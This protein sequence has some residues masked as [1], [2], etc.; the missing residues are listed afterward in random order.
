MKKRIVGIVGLVMVLAIA[1]AIALPV[2]AQ[3]G[4]GTDYSGQVDAVPFPEGLEWINVPA[5]LDWAQL[6]GKVVL[7]DFW[8]YGCINCIHIIP[9]L[10]RLEAEYPDELVVIGVHSAKFENEGDTENIRQIVQRYE[11]EHPVVNDS[12][13]TVW[14]AWGVRAWPTAMLVDPQG[15]VFGYHAGEGVYDVL[16][17]IIDG[18]VRQF[19]DAGLI[20]RAPIELALETEARVETLLAFPGKVLADEAGERLF[21]ADSNHNRIVVADL[22]TYEVLEVIGGRD[23]GDMDGSYAVARFS[24]PQGMALSAD[25]SML[26]VADTENHTLRAVDLANQTVQTIAGTGY[27]ARYGARGGIGTEAALSS[28][29]DLVRVDD[30]LYIAMAG[31]HQLW[32]YD[33][34]TGEVGVHSGS[35]R[36]DLIDATHANAELAQPSGITT[37]GSVLYFADSEASAIRASDVDPA[38]GV[39]TLVGTGLF[40]FGDRD[41]V[42]DDALLQHPLGVVYADEV[43][44]VADTYNSK[45][46]VLDPVTREI[47]SLTG[48]Q[49]GG[50][51]DGALDAALFDEPGGISYANGRLYVADTNNHA[52]RVIDLAAGTVESITFTNPDLLLAERESVIVASPFTGNDVM[53]DGVTVAEG[54]AGAALVLTL[55]EGYKV[56][57]LTVSSV[58]W[59]VDGVVVQM[60]DDA[61]RLPFID[62][63]APLRVPVSLSAGEAL[64]DVNLTLYYCEAVN[65]SLCFVERVRF[66]QPVQVSA[67]AEA[68]DIVLE[69]TVVPPVAE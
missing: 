3:G 4:D 2:L 28:P 68:A 9:D 24:K 27:Q 34:V 35:G 16:K 51:L 21:I 23:A 58:E 18:M 6:E 15:M 14:S 43:V 66:H 67:D 13:F 25:G 60:S 37:D 54:E 19:D 38:G 41:G 12:E 46:K 55:P 33:L 26:Y 11:V 49:A 45:I 62:L 57:T 30:V 22:N 50:Y 48:V 69:H 53:L 40:D 17:P 61:A 47:E 20:D 36:E 8:T 52:I 64:L 32:R 1:A 44:Y 39:A 59:Q 56:N 63:E 65:E 29:W 10:K 42:G 5:P 31:P 7:L